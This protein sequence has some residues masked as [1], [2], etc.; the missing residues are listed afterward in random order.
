MCDIIKKYPKDLLGYAIVV[1]VYLAN[2]NPIVY[3]LEGKQVKIRTLTFFHDDV[4]GGRGTINIPVRFESAG[5][6]NWYY[7]VPDSGNSDEPVGVL[8]DGTLYFVGDRVQLEDDGHGYI[9]GGIM[10]ACKG[11]IVR[12]RRDDTDHFYG[13]YTDK[14][15]F[16][17]VKSA[18][19]TLI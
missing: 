2:P 16:G 17:F 13:I 10:C 11:W 5:F 4:R 12:I 1:R 19:I 7:V 15:E 6:L 14:G 18:R 3:V 9:G 8:E